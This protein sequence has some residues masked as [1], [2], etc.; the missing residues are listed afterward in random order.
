MMG[1]Q[2]WRNI[3]QAMVVLL[4]LILLVAAWS[5]APVAL[6]ASL[7]RLRAWIAAAGPWGPVVYVLLYTL[8]IVLLV[9]GSLL[10]LSAGL[11]YGLWG[12]PLALSGATAGAALS[13][14][15]GRHL[16][17]AWLRRRSDGHPI[18]QAVEGAVT[19][20]GWRFVAMVRLSPLLP[21]NLLNYYFAVTR[22][23]FRR[24]LAGTFLGIIPGTA[25][26]VLLASAG[27]AYTMGGMR[28]PLKLAM[29]AVG[30]VVTAFVCRIVQRRV[31][32]ALQDAKAG[33][34]RR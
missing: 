15:A 22:I 19:E 2:G 27:Y 9:P 14:L 26:N 11:A 18:L 32:T 31:Q 4:L 23:S 3:A 8:A 28:H 30:L 1:G 34:E 6:I 24:Y 7:A 20:G 33:L 16:V 5:M 29:L 10:A 17:G 13:F 12:L 21:F 25:V